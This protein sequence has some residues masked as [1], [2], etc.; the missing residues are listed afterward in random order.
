MAPW[1][2]AA[3]AT[4]QLGGQNIEAGTVREYGK[5][6]GYRKHKGADKTPSRSQ[7][8]LIDYFLCI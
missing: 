3:M 4:F 7:S 6:T 8:I 1:P 5:A 2:Q